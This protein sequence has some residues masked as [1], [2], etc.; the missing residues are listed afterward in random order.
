M[1]T[2]RRLTLV[3]LLALAGC[4]SLLPKLEAPRLSIVNV[5]L[6]KSD[7]LQQQLRVRMRVQNPN[8][9]TLP[10]RSI[11]YSIEVAGEEFAHGDSDRNF[12]VPALGET[13]FDVN[14][15]VNAA[16]LLLRLA[17]GGGRNR[18]L[19]YRLVGTV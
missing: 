15:T 6:L 1:N 17:G 7:L 5:E 9:R 12:V 19:N 2:M 16:S 11:E 3:A 4:S 18:E 14:V 8:D 10:V 13:E